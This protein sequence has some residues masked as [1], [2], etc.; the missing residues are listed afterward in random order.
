M[1]LFAGRRV[2]GAGLKEVVSALADAYVWTSMNKALRDQVMSL[3]ADEKLELAME[4]WDDIHP[5]GSLRP[6]EACELSEEQMTEI[7]RRVAEHERNPDSAKPWEEVRAR[8][9]ARLK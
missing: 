9:W 2:E 5:P 7:R 8:L 3:P 6:G 1:G 4:L